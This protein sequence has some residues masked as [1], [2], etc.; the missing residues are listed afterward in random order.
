MVPDKISGD[1]YRL[2]KQHVGIKMD[3][4]FRNNVNQPHMAT[5]VE[6][7]IACGYNGSPDD[8]LKALAPHVKNEKER[9]KLDNKISDESFCNYKP[10]RAVELDRSRRDERLQ[11]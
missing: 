11:K 5:L 1:A 4:A 2:Y 7:A 9:I 8:V 3:R 10:S 6:V